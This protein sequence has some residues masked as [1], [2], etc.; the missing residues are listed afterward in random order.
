MG[1]SPSNNRN[2]DELDPELAELIGTD[3]D[4]SSQDDDV[5]DFSELF[6]EPSGFEE[7]GESSEDTAGTDELKS[8]GFTLP[9]QY[10]E[11]PKQLFADK[12][13][14][15]KILTGQGDLAKRIHSLLASY[16]NAQDSEERSNARNRFIPAYWELAGN[17]ATQLPREVKD[18]KRLML[19]FGVL[20]PT[21]ISQSQRDMLSRVILENRTDEPIYYVDEWLE[22]V[23]RGRI[24]PSAV[25]ETKL[26]KR[27]EGQKVN[28]MLE[29]V[30][31]KHEAQLS[32]IRTR[33]QELQEQEQLLV[34]KAKSLQEHAQLDQYDGLPA[35]YTDA[36]RNELSEI[37]GIVKQ[38]SNLN[39]EL[40]RQYNELDQIKNQLDD[41]KEKEGDYE[42]TSVDDKTIR[43]EL[44]TVRQMVKMCVGRQG[45]HF[46]LLM[47]QYLR[48]NLQE[49]GTRENVLKALADIER[50]DPSIFHRT[51]KQQT[52][53]IVPN[54]VLLPCYGENGICW[55]PYERYNRATSRGRLCIPM[56]PKDLRGAIIAACGDLR[57]QVAKEKA[58]HYWMEEGLTGWYYQ[59]FSDQK[60]KGDVKDAF[61]QD[62]VLWIQ[63]ESE[64][65]Q[66]LPR[67][68][69]D[70]FWRYIPFPQ[71]VKD[72]LKNRGFVYNELYKKD[73]NRAMSDGY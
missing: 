46:P 50:L 5:P 21:T 57:W 40:S 29:K 25:D 7:S 13:Y 69:R 47:K 1:S 54:V 15:K 19:R 61:V 2:S 33:A 44:N 70:I 65:T 20:L 23:S 39:K 34:S 63:R 27:Q 41:L 11:E 72:M 35:P 3:D 38:L 58:Q 8:K 52:N 73:Q 55:E 53:R 14:Y 12:S 24:K 22:M 60:M 62:Y 48:G 49:I 71:D 59:W 16:L 4:D 6:G 18:A 36:Q 9:T 26:S 30:R 64:G 67:E 43:G 66:K 68:V 45:N 10:E 37:S 31:G 17:L 28:A 42:D 51:Y 56:Y 32:L